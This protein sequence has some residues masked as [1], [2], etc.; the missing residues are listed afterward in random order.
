MT[1]LTVDQLRIRVPGGMAVDGVSFTLAP[2]EV[3]ALL[4]E[5]GAG[6]SLIGAALAGLLPRGS[7]LAGGAILLDGARIDHLPEAERHRLRGRRISAVFQDSA[8][9]LD[10]LR[11][12]GAHLAETL[13]CHNPLSARVLRERVGDWL[14]AVA[15]PADLARAYPHQLSGGQLQRVALALALCARPEVLVADEP[16]SAQDV[17]SRAPF[18][19]LLRRLARGQRSSLVLI[20]SDVGTVAAAADR[21]AVMHAGRIIETGAAAKVLSAP[22]HPYTAALLARPPGLMQVTPAFS[23][24]PAGCAFQPACPHASQLCATRPDLPGEGAAC[25]HPLV[26]K[27]SSPASSVVPL[28][29]A[30]DR[31]AGKVAARP[32]RRGRERRRD[33]PFPT[34]P[35]RE[36]RQNN[37]SPDPAA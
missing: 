26:A 2:G 33:L 19:A 22:A 4:G 5:S 3:L 12:I 36:E 8:V 30:L 17:P 18:A 28:S 21:V 9:A 23:V 29:G 31:G 11:C 34:L 37:E 20:S 24:P 35:T 7:A 14:D 1:L 32:E 15:I 10:P 13:A 25:W 16:T 6:K 27:H